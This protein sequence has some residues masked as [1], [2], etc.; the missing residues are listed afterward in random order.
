VDQQLRDINTRLNNV[1]TYLRTNIV[2]KDDLADLRADLPTRGD[3]AQ[4]QS[5]VDGI[6]KLFVESD[7][8]LK[9]VS[10]RTSRMEAWITKAAAK[11]GPDYRP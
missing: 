9:I 11:L 7:Q 1:I 3:F 10:H 4:L 8:E 6:A 5:S 2:T